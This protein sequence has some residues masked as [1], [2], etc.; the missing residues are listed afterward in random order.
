MLNSYDEPS[1]YYTSGGPV[2]T[3]QEERDEIITISEVK[4]EPSLDS[5][6]IL[7]SNCLNGLKRENTLESVQHFKRDLSLISSGKHRR[8]KSMTMSGTESPI[9]KQE[10]A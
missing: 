9:K 10:Y 3:K 5:G 4:E 1:T 6:V 2:S 8:I 7:I